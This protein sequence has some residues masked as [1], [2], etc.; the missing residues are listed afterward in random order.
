MREARMVVPNENDPFGDLNRLRI[1]VQPIQGIQEFNSKPLQTKI[2]GEFLKGPIPLSWLSVAAKIRAK[3][4]LALAIAIWFEVGRKKT[5]KVKLTKSLMSRFGI[6]RKAKYRAIA[7]LE[8]HK[9]ISVF[10]NEGKSVIVQ[11]INF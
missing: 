6:G 3:S 2:K 11:V 5:Y 7:N 8:K 9:L 10:K 1:Q 4:A